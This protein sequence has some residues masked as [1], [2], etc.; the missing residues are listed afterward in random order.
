[1][2]C[3]SSNA[4]ADKQNV[5]GVSQSRDNTGGNLWA[6][7]YIAPAI[8]RPAIGPPLCTVLTP[9]FEEDE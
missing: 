9:S 1:M 7:F 2:L 6:D 8:C 5:A 3:L 4:L